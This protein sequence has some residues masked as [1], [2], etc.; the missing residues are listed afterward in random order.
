MQAQNI[1]RRILF[2]YA[3]GIVYHSRMGKVTL[4][5]PCHGAISGTVYRG[6]VCPKNAIG[7]GYLS[8]SGLVHF[9][10]DSDIVKLFSDEFKV[11]EAKGAK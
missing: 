9:F 11:K 10:E 2:D 4:V 3:I 7:S 8:V 6:R 1:T 5:L